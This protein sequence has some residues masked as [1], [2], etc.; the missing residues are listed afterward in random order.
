MVAA[1]GLGDRERRSVAPAG[2]CEGATD[3][4]PTCH[5]LRDHRYGL[6]HFPMKRDLTSRSVTVANRVVRN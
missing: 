3:E 1:G 4:G 6:P 2:H 5:R